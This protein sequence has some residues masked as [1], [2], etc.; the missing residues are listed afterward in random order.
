VPD[1]AKGQKEQGRYEFARAAR[2]T[3]TLALT[4]VLGTAFEHN[5]EE[6]RALKELDLATVPGLARPDPVALFALLLQQE[7]RESTKRSISWRIDLTV[8]ETEPVS[9]AAV[10]RPGPG[11]SKQPIS[12]HIRRGGD[13]RVGFNESGQGYGAPPITRIISSHLFL[14][15][16]FNALRDP[17]QFNLR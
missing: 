2:S 7:N 8:N 10:A 3:A 16:S 17:R 11:G 12:Q 14:A 4:A 9:L 5:E 6:A 13:E 1:S 15:E